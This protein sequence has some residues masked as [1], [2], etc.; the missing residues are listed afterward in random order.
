MSDFFLTNRELALLLALLLWLT[1]TAI[2]AWRGGSSSELLTPVRDL[3]SALADRRILIPALTYVGWM[4]AAL[5][6]ANA[7][8]LWDVALTKATVLWWLLSGL[9]L[10]G[11]GIEA[12]ERAGAITST[13]KRLLNMV[14][15][16]QFLANL[17]SFPLFIEML[18]QFLA[19]PCTLVWVWGSARQERSLAT[20]LASGY[21]QLLGIA[22]LAWGITRLVSDW[23]N[24]DQDL[25][26][27]EVVMPFWLTAVALAFMSLFALYMVYELTFSVM[28]TQSAAGFSW[29]HKSAVL[30]RCGLRLRAVRAARPTASWLANESGFRFTWKWT[31]R[32]LRE[33]RKR[34]AKE[35]AEAKRLTDN[36]GVVGTDSA[37]RQLDQ[38]EHAQ[39]MKALRWLHTCHMGHYRKRGDRYFAGLEVIVDGLSD[40]YELPQPNNIEMHIASDGQSW[41]AARRTVTGHWFAIGAAGPPSD[42]WFYDGPTAPNDFPNESLWDQWVPDVHA[43]NWD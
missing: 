38:R 16:F 10:F 19:L 6:A 40:K 8:G 17:A 42:Q 39:T 37:G 7:L 33:D 22:A 31:H 9:G 29:R 27:R 21:L 36:A 3:L 4:S 41:Y 11:P 34:R 12:V 23:E 5:A 24:I 35:A 30:M 13:F 26:W 14:V 43:P 32:V 15:V 2:L 1:I 25:L 20:R 18:A 28:R